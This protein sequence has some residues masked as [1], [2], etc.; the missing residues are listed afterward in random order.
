MTGEGNPPRLAEFLPFGVTV[1]V[2]AFTGCV[3]DPLIAVGEL[4]DHEDDTSSAS[5]RRR[6]VKAAI[7]SALVDSHRKLLSL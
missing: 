7:I 1:A 5:S 6:T 2:L 4:G 3:K